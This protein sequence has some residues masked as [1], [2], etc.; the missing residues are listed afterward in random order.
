MYAAWAEGNMA[1]QTVQ[2]RSAVFTKYPLPSY[3]KW[4]SLVLV[5]IGVATFAIG[6]GSH[7]NRVWPA[8]L[9]SFFYFTTLAVGGLFFAA[10]QHA[11]NAGWS[12]T[13]RRFVEAFASFIPVAFVFGLI[14]LAGG[15]NLYT[16][17][18]PEIVASDALLQAKQAYLNQGFFW[19]RTILFFVLWMVFGFKILGNSVKQD[20][21]GD[22]KYTHSNLRWSIAFLLVFALS[23]S[24]FSV[25]TLMSLEP[26][27]FSTIFGVYCFAG[28]FQSVMALAVLFI[29]RLVKN[30]TMPEYINENH[31]HDV[32]KFLFA[33]TIFYA[34]I[35]FSQFML[36]WYANIPEETSFFLHRSHSGWMS[37]SMSLLVFKFV[38]PFLAL[39]PRWAKRTP[40]HASA[41]AVL[42]LIMQYVDIFWLVYP[43][44]NEGHLVFSFWEVGVFLGFLGA[45]LFTVSRFLDKYSVVPMKD[46]RLHES[47]AHHI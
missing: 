11:T 14:L 30:K 19:V 5:V 17:L 23:Y 38:V 45:F 42:I 40:A 21:S 44:F 12:V 37:V 29:A 33:F 9:T 36:I 3:F 18:N 16:W 6:V 1:T 8:Y 39:L 41:V 20:Q 32:A 25:D 46:P 47:V 31:L 10:I 28:L 24:L 34:Y 4:L 27:W 43:N 7:P 2:P 13:T 35:A 26:H 22:D 15:K